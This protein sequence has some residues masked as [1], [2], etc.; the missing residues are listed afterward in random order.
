MPT[1]Q[2]YRSHLHSQSI[3]M[4]VWIRNVRAIRLSVEI[5]LVDTHTSLV[6]DDRSLALLIGRK[7]DSVSST[8]RTVRRR[9]A[10]SRPLR[11]FLSSLPSRKASA[12]F[13]GHQ[14]VDWVKTVL[15]F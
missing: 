5:L 9:Q 11:I 13:Q 12:S 14:P 3:E 8:N 7:L 2:V 10:A 4:F 15:I 6:L 1:M